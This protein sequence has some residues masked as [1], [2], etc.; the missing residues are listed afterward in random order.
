MQH[1]VL[2]NW[3]SDC[4]VTI[5]CGRHHLTM[6]MMGFDDGVHSQKIPYFLGILALCIGRGQRDFWLERASGFGTGDGI[7]I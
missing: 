7:L 6:D 4:D 3:N 1:C 2:S 5:D